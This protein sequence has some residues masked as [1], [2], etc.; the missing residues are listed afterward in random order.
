[1]EYYSA[2]K[3]N[4]FL[5]QQVTTWMNLKTTMLGKRSQTQKDCKSVFTTHDSIY[6]ILKSRQELTMAIDISLCLPGCGKAEDCPE[7]SLMA[8]VG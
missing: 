7:R 3:R 2:I 5:K 1:M 8:F 6:M 4:E